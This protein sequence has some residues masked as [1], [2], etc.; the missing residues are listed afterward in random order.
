MAKLFRL[1]FNFHE[2]YPIRIDLSE[3][4]LANDFNLV[5]TK[6]EV[7]SIRYVF[8]DILLNFN[9]LPSMPSY[10]SNTCMQV[11]TKGIREKYNCIIVGTKLPKKIEDAFGLTVGWQIIWMYNKENHTLATYGNQRASF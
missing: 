5:L 8:K 4:F 9:L 2:E 7:L 10:Y 11:Q 3:K 6:T 1:L